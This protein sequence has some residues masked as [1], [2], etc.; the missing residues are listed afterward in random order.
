ML[1]TFSV[2]GNNLMEVNGLSKADF[3]KVSMLGITKNNFTCNYLSEYLRQWN[4]TTLLQDDELL[5]NKSH[6]EK[7]YCNE[8]T[9]DHYIPGFIE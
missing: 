6:V 5:L 7:I 2:D 4:D 9:E 1:Q 8:I 3:P